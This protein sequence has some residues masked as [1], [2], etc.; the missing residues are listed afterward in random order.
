MAALAIQDGS[1][2]IQDVTFSA[3]TGGG[4]TVAGG[5]A[6]GGW[7]APVVLVV[8]NRDAAAKTVTV[9]GVGYVVP[10]TTGVA[11]IPINAGTYG[12]VVPVTYSAVTSL[13][14]AAVRLAAAP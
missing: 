8:N 2:G 7:S 3:A 10:L 4:D 14:V 6:A 1:A 11:L 13:F 9:R 5:A 12:M